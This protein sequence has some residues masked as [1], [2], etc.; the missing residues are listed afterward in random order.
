MEIKLHQKVFLRIQA[1]LVIKLFIIISLATSCS[2]YK[3][4]TEIESYNLINSELS[5]LKKDLKSN[6]HLE[7]KFN[8]RINDLLDDI[9]L[10]KQNYEFHFLNTTYGVEKNI[11]ETLFNKKQIEGY[12]RTI[13]KDDRI[14]KDLIINLPFK[15]NVDLEYKIF[16]SKVFFTKNRKFAWM[17]YDINIYS[18]TFSSGISIYRKKHNK[19]FLYK[20]IPLEI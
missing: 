18:E 19:W 6:F 13:K 7:M 11:A 1:C 10:T 16:L 15:K 4:I 8:N 17:K 14:K 9:L 2:G 5:Y 3:K 12:L 20:R